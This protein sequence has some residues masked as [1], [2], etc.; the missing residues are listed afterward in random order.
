MLGVLLLFY[1][2]FSAEDISMGEVC[3]TIWIFEVAAFYIDISHLL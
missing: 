1:S 3:E 2:S